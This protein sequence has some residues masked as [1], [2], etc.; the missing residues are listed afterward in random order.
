MLVNVWKR[1]KAI[2]LRAFKNTVFQK[3]AIAVAPLVGGPDR[4]WTHRC[5]RTNVRKV[6]VK[7]WS[8]SDENSKSY[9]GNSEI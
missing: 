7:I 6:L 4:R 1:P 9:A 8:E 2:L 3:S 5:N